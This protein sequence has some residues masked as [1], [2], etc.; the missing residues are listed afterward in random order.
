MK[1]KRGLVAQV[2]TTCFLIAGV[3]SAT[4]LVLMWMSTRQSL[5]T[6]NLERL[7]RNA[8]Y[9]AEG[10]A[11]PLA[12]NDAPTIDEFMAPL[13]RA[14]GLRFTVTD[15]EGVVLVDTTHGA[16]RGRSLR[17]LSEIE[18]ATRGESTS[19]IPDAAEE[20]V[21]YFF[22]AQPVLR[23]DVIVGTVRTGI[24]TGAMRSGQGSLLL[25]LVQFLAIVLP[26]A[27]FASILFAR[28]FTAPIE[29]MR[30]GAERLGEGFLQRRIPSFETVELN[31]LGD[32]LNRMAS[33]LQTRIEEITRERNEREAILASMVEGVLAIDANDRILSM[34]R[35]AEELFVLREADARGKL[36]Q[37]VMRHVELQQY[38]RVTQEA[39]E[40]QAREAANMARPAG[41]FTTDKPGCTSNSKSATGRS[42]TA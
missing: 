18:M 12:A 23:D 31:D 15:A 39:L 28:R 5:F 2:F 42:W 40:K 10:V 33:Q 34:N 21:R 6:Q 37:E 9:V 36:V 29:I 38:I 41:P 20:G 4:A 17:S 35:M 22:V 7:S 25:R 1:N 8:A 11:D 3:C 27:A 32:A 24:P 19:L 30:R 16:L 13:A 14:T 26:F